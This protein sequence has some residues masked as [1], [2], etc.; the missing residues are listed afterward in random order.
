[1]DIN[2]K[3]LEDALVAFGVDAQ[4]DLVIEECAELIQALIKMRR[5]WG[6]NGGSVQKVREEI[7]DAYIMVEQASIIFDEV[8]VQGFVDQKLVR[9]RTRLNTFTNDRPTKS[10]IGE[11]VI[12]STGERGAY[13][14]ESRS[15][16]YGERSLS[17]KYE[18][19]RKL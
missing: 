5:T 14:E 6:N 18:Q 13:K 16:A 17:D 15:D 10:N 8:A 11:E 9:L 2:R 1:M 3:V 12:S 19:P 7:A 4:L